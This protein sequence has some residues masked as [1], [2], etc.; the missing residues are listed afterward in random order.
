MDITFNELSLDKIF[1]DKIEK[2]H[3]KDC[4][5][6]FV[7]LLYSL[8]KNDLLDDLILVSDGQSFYEYSCINEWLSNSKVDIEKKRFLGSFFEKKCQYIDAK[9]FD[10]Q[11]ICTIDQ[12]ELAGAGFAFACEMNSCAISVITNE[13]W[14]KEEIEGSLLRISY[15]D[16]VVQEKRKIC[17]YSFHSNIEKFEELGIKKRIREY[18]NISSGQDLWE[19]RENLFPNLVF[20]DCVKEQLYKDPERFHILQIMHKLKY[21]Q[22]YFATYDGIYDPKKL[23]LNAR[24]ESDS[25]KDNPVLKNKRRFEKPEGGAEFFYDHIGFRGKFTGRIHFLPAPNKEK[26]CYIGYIGRHLETKKFS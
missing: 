2:Y 22:D 7:E 25:V 12:K 18:D 9:T 1:V 24:T 26:K 14:K 8:K 19:N 6:K 16:E 3:V 10:S 17:N 21:L 20:C 23:G 13:V 5:S 11:F 4:I 15:E